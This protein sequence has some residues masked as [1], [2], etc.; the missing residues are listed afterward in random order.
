MSK[1]LKYIKYVLKHK[2]YVFIECCKLGIPI[3][4]LLHDISKFRPSEFKVYADYFY[5]KPKPI[6]LVS[7]PSVPRLNIFNIYTQEQLE[8]DFDRA[9]LHHQHRN[10]HHWQYWILRNDSGTVEYIDMP[11][12]YV[13]EMVAD[14]IGA[15]RAING[16]YSGYEE[17]VE[18]YNKNKHNMEMSENT[19]K[20]VVDI[21]TYLYC[22]DDIF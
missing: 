17:V 19:R 2:H 3:R 10:K 1:Y 14:W 18:W 15:G 4:G 5:G 20:K 6:R 9:W 7:H 21:I 11:T 16:K 22:N 12:K 8:K 13:K